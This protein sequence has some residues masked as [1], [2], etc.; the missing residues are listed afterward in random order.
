MMLLHIFSTEFS[1]FAHDA[2]QVQASAPY[3]SLK[4]TF[5]SEVCF[6]V[7]ESVCATKV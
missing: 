5:Q 4:N 2:Q 6:H 7:Y 3:F 1:W